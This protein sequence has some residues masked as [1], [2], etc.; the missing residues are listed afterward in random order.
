MP[1]GGIL[2][3]LF[4]SAS[5]YMPYGERFFALLHFLISTIRLKA[6][7]MPLSATAWSVANY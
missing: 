7:S 2:K 5:K 4:L 6:A 3:Y 1:R